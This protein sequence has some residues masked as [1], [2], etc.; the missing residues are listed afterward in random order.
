MDGTGESDMNDTPFALR[1]KTQ[2]F[3]VNDADTVG[4]IYCNAAGNDA[5]SGL[6]T[7]QPKATL[8]AIFDQY[9]LEAGDTV[10]VDTGAYTGPINAIWSRSGE[11]G[12]PVKIVGNTNLLDGTMF[13]ASTNFIFDI[14]A[15]DFELWHLGVSGTNR[16]VVLA[17]NV[18]V[19]LGGMLFKGNANGVVALATTN[20]VLRNSAFWNTPVGADVSWARDTTFENLTFALPTNAA[21]K[22]ANLE[23]ET[24]IQN[25]IFIPTNGGFAYSIGAETSILQNA[26]MD[27]NLYDFGAATSGEGNGW[28]FRGAPADLRHWQLTMENDWRSAITNADLHQVAATKFDAHPRSTAG[29][30]QATN[31]TWKKDSETSWAVDHGNPYESVGAE[32]K[33][34]GKR[35]NIGAYG[36]TVQASKSAT[37]MWETYDLRSFDDG[38]QTLRSADPDWPLVWSAELFGTNRDVIVWFTSTGTNKTGWIKLTECKAF[39]EYFVW[40]IAGEQFLT[41]SGRWLITDT[42]QNVLA[43]SS[44]NLTIT[45]D[46]LG[47]SKA[48]YEANGLMRFEWKGGLGGQHYWILYSD[49]FGKS[50]CMWPSRYNGPAKIHR[51]NF[52]LSEGEATAIFEDRTSYEH[53][54]RWYTITTND[55][56]SMMTNGVYV[57]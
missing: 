28:F 40:N 23:G 49:D 15:S 46:P 30:F 56:T 4:D 42:N 34:N 37:N 41:G 25:N 13:T 32:P 24:V 54:T 51:S 35:R 3:Y 29:R 50:W 55:P 57:P 31:S 10:Y 39:D 17:T 33:V 16:G 38:P 45:R 47:I 9:D 18:N 14:K 1:N 20:L 48:P 22:L 5:N 21:L 44:G 7:N 8:Q 2:A 52:T 27:Y 19:V 11:V 53:R 12:K 43:I 26:K 6:A 36:G